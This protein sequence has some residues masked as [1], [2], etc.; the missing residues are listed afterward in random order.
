M[1]E[2]LKGHSASFNQNDVNSSC[3]TLNSQ[4]ITV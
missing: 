3:D 2:F 4:R 1:Q